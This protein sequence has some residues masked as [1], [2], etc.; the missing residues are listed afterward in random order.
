MHTLSD[1]QDNIAVQHLLAVH[2]NQ[3]RKAHNRQLERA[4]KYKMYLV[5]Y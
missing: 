1:W 4:C 5:T 3:S 2:V